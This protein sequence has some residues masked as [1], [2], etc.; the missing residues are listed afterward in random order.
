ADLVEEDRADV[1]P[2]ADETA[3]RRDAPELDL[4]RSHPEER[5]R[6]G[7][8]D[9]EERA[10]HAAQPRE[11]RALV[12]AEHGAE[13]HVER[14]A[15]H[16]LVDR[17][18]LPDRPARDRLLGDLAHEAPVDVHPLAVE[19]RRHP[20]T[21]AEVALAVEDEDRVPAEDRAEERRQRL[22]RAERLGVAGE[23]RLH[24]VGIA[25]RHHGGLAERAHRVRLAVRPR[26]LVDDA[27][28]PER[29]AEALEETREART[30]GQ[31]RRA[32][33]RKR[34]RGFHRDLPLRAG[35]AAGTV[36]GGPGTS[37]HGT[38]R[39]FEPD[40]PP[41]GPRLLQAVARRATGSPAVAAAL[42]ARR[43]TW[44]GERSGSASVRG[45]VPRTSP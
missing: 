22:A 11:R 2:P 42:V 21:L 7:V 41:R 43:T 25:E 26:P 5:G 34:G 16:L 8:R 9:R 17:E 6:G 20:A 3:P 36:R 35:Q 12:D 29:V 30:G 24:R 40:A 33:R 44:S 1:V 13:D 10:D 28:G 15:L 37:L 32:C 27:V 4:E 31:D 39:R 38:R 19:R 14:D 18:R 45:R 23:D